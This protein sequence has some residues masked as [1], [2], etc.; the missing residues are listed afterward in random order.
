AE[1]AEGVLAIS[2]RRRI[3]RGA[4]AV[5]TRLFRPN[6]RLPELF[7]AP[8]EA[9]YCV[10]AVDGTGDQNLL[11]HHGRCGATFAWQ[12]RL[13]DDVLAV[14][15]LGQILS[16]SRAAQIVRPAPARP[17][18]SVSVG[19]EERRGSEKHKNRD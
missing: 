12:P 10:G 17:E 5:L 1:I 7:A 6:L 13:P 2:H 11:A 19:G 9:E 4:V 3:R 14:A 18:L 8:I 16:F 15:E